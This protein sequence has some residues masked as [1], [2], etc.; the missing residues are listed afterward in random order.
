MIKPKSLTSLS[1]LFPCYNEALNIGTMIEQSIAIGDGYGIDYEV[2]IVDDGSK[3][4]TA[5]VKAENT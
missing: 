4:A 5:A 1:F 3:D 2:V